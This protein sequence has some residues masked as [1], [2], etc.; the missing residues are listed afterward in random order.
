MGIDK[1]LEL[2]R[3]QLRVKN[4]E[5]KKRTA[6]KEKYED[7]VK[8][9]TLV[10]QKKIDD[11][12][13]ML[14]E[15]EEEVKHYRGINASLMKNRPTKDI[16]SSQTPSSKSPV[17]ELKQVAVRD[18]K[19]TNAISDLERK[20]RRLA[21]EIEDEIRKG[22][23]LAKEKSI[24]VKEVRRLNNDSS[25]KITEKAAEIENQSKE[26]LDQHEAKLREKE[27][28]LNEREKRL[29]K[30]KEPLPQKVSRTDDPSQA[31]MVEGVHVELDRLKLEKDLI[32]NEMIKEKRKYKTKL[33]M[34]VMK[35]SQ[36]W[37]VKLN[38][39]R[40]QRK[41]AG[42][43]SDNDDLIDDLMTDDKAPY[44]MVTYADM[45][46]LLLT[47]FI[48]YYSISASN[49]QKFEEVILGKETASI[50]LLELL[51]SVK[52]NESLEKFTGLRSDNIV[53]DIND[54]ATEEHFSSVI[55]VNTDDKSKI[56][57]RISG[58]TLYESGKADLRMESK[59][60]LDEIARIL[61]AYPTHKINI[62][63][64]T[65]DTEIQSEQYESNWELSA[66]RASSALRF[67]L[68]KNIEPKRLTATGYADTFPVASNQT[69]AGRM[70]NRRVEF[71]LEKER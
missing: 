3:E 25:S 65:D 51:D 31:E 55:E 22:R 35:I 32:E 42:Q 49:M 10:N 62:Q 2:A 43:F 6:E 69:E 13:Q 4:A 7:R 19:L 38:K 24:L 53:T 30:I 36:E 21:E 15:K 20:N 66:A 57:V 46:T 16:K 70:K 12:E 29:A 1:N 47:F 59:P 63:G 5:I 61:K 68:D 37:G 39:I 48:L 45:T 33:H 40:F 50:G 58:E 8:N 18:P 64:H 14:A 41:K 26:I 17:I 34:E 27:E 71:V 23:Q 67:F 56:V 9:I 52:V 54:I 44:W 60:V 28:E 11:L